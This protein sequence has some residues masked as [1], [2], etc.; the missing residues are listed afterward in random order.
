MRIFLTGSNGQLGRA[1][2][3][4]LKGSP[5]QVHAP[6]RDA[7]DLANPLQ[8]RAQ[9]TAFQPDIILNPAAYTAVDQA[10]NEPAMA[11]AINAQALEVMADCAKKTGAAILH[12]S[13]DY[14]FDGSKR[15]ADGNYLGYNEND[16]CAPLNC[17]GE[18]K[19]AGELALADSGVAHI[20]LRTSWVYTWYGKNFFLTMLKLAQQ[21]QELSIVADQFGAPTSADFL[22]RASLQLLPQ[23]PPASANDWW[24]EHGGIY[25][26]TCSGL[27]TWHGFACEI[28]AQAKQAGLLT[29]SPTLQAIPARDY[30][31]PAQRP[32]NSQL[33]CAR[34]QA[35][36]AVQCPSWQ[37]ALSEVI[38]N[39]RLSLSGA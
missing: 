30:P 7:C 25:H 19:R 22:A 23:L 24:Q 34:L 8:L 29:N 21:R 3:Q 16:S 31:T 27:T 1:L 18:S 11:F 35:K 13:T 28:F 17:Y 6:Q 39:Y 4:Q 37:Q 33:N 10:Q 12:Y 38:Q 9:I 32:S 26:L 15:D 20:C 2:A 36:F 5:H 14:V